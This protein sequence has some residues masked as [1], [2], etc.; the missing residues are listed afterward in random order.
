MKLILS[1]EKRFKRR[2]LNETIKALMCDGFP[3]LKQVSD[4]ND[5]QTEDSSYIN[6]GGFNV[7]IRISIFG[8]QHQIQWNATI[9]R[10]NITHL[11]VIGRILHSKLTD[12]FQLTD[13]LSYDF[14]KKAAEFIDFA[15]KMKFQIN[16]IKNGA[17]NFL[18]EHG[19]EIKVLQEKIEQEVFEFL[20]PF[21]KR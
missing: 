19:N 12:D 20:K 4:L 13:S 15:N 5:F 9:D 6:A 21:V 1:A 14:D 2:L 18:N 11:D 8:N 10:K 17:E 3:N 16:V 7:F